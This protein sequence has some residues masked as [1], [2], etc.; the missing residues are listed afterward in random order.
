MNTENNKKII[1]DDSINPD[2][3]IN[4]GLVTINPTYSLYGPRRDMDYYL[5]PRSQFYK[6]NLARMVNSGYIPTGAIAGW[7]TSKIK[8][9]PEYHGNRSN[10]RHMQSDARYN[11]RQLKR[12]M[13]YAGSDQ[14]SIADKQFYDKLGLGMAGIV[15]APLAA[16]A[17]GTLLGGVIKTVPTATNWLANLSKTGIQ[18]KFVKDMLMES[19]IGMT[20]D[21]L[22]RE[23]TPY[24][25]I[26]DGLVK[27]G[28]KLYYNLKHDTPAKANAAYNKFA[29][30][31]HP[32]LTFGAEFANPFNLAVP[33]VATTNLY[34][35]FRN[36]DGMLDTKP[37]LD[38]INNYYKSPVIDVENLDPSQIKPLF[39][40]YRKVQKIWDSGHRVEYRRHPDLDKLMVNGEEIPIK[41]IHV[42]P[43]FWK[44]HPWLKPPLE[45]GHLYLAGLVSDSDYRINPL[46]SGGPWHQSLPLTKEVANELDLAFADFLKRQK[47]NGGVYLSQY[48][49]QLKFKPGGTGGTGNFLF[50]LDGEVGSTTF[51]IRPQRLDS[52]LE[53]KI[54]ADTPHLV[55][56]NGV[57]KRI[58]K[59]HPHLLLEEYQGHPYVPEFIP[60]EK[61]GNL[62]LN[63]EIPQQ[64]A[65]I[66]NISDNP[67]LL[68]DENGQINLAGWNNLKINLANKLGK[69]YEEID[70]ILKDGT[71]PLEDHL[72]R[73]AYSA[74]TMPIPKGTTRQQ[75]VLGSFLHDIGRLKYMIGDDAVHA[76][77]GGTLLQ[78]IPIEGLTEDVLSAINF[79]ASREQLNAFNKTGVRDGINYPLLHAVSA[80]DVSRGLPYISARDKFPYL[81]G[82]ETSEPRIPFDLNENEQM[83]I[84]RD[85]LKQRGYEIDENLSIEDQWKQLESIVQR[86]NTYVRGVTSGS[87]G[88]DIIRD[89]GITDPDAQEHILATQPVKRYNGQSGTFDDYLFGKYLGLNRTDSGTIYISNNPQFSANYGNL[90]FIRRGN[91]SDYLRLKDETPLQYMSRLMPIYL[92]NYSIEN[93]HITPNRSTPNLDGLPKVTPEVKELYE[94]F[95][96]TET[97]ARL[98]TLGH[99]LKTPLEIR[100]ETWSPGLHVTDLP[101]F[102]RNLTFVTAPG[103]AGAY[104]GPYYKPAFHV[105]KDK[106]ALLSTFKKHGGKLK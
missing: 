39:E 45:D 8:Y 51:K 74:Q 18:N 42:I 84:V 100:P 92:D 27:Q 2:T 30:K 82:Y 12:A 25:G 68:V 95:G 46:Y 87:G 14:Q 26:A 66:L 9:N 62:S 101:G 31:E 19:A 17:A 36:T 16:E 1:L 32:W 73:S 81:F 88:A 103:Y 56:E 53:F 93:P 91:Q 33:A 78:G 97:D 48:L 47:F 7:N 34:R 69:S 54:D 80:A 52:G 71:D 85:Y 21:Q 76:N 20:G 28:A 11:K 15:A 77:A 40:K 43:E 61:Y 89:L 102:R 99:S 67:N 6:K 38:F 35:Q 70:K 98:N 55:M 23:L 41:N 3:P 49:D 63:H 106:D 90:H 59:P 57:I 44:K 5:T 79:H 24:N 50:L 37:M 60:G 72:L 58:K 4:T 105:I 22:A 96:F 13:K 29:S 10:F 65:S 94:H 104:V 75:L 86:A 64:S 83:R